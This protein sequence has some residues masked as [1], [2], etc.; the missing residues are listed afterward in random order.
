MG[1]PEPWRALAEAYGGVVR[2]AAV[3][4]VHYSTVERWAFGRVTP[5][6][7]VQRHV[8][9]LAT[10]KGLPSPWEPRPLVE[11]TSEIAERLAADAAPGEQVRVFEAWGPRGEHR[12]LV[13]EPSSPDVIPLDSVD[14]D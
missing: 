2:F 10:R 12:I 8:R 3:V 9:S 6:G 11:L 13:E 1:L 4:G 14:E 7:I 5:S